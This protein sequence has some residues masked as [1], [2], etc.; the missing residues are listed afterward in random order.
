VAYPGF[1]SRE[2]APYNRE[3]F[4]QGLRDLGQVD[5]K[6]FDI[7]YRYADGVSDRLEGLAK[8]LVQLKPDVIY[9]ISAPSVRAITETIPIVSPTLVGD[10]VR[11]RLAASHA[12]PGGNVTGILNY[13]DGLVGKQLEISR[14]DIGA[15]PNM[16][17]PCLG[18]ANVVRA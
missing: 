1:A 15:Y 16:S 2:S 4:L 11:M 13:V 18:T 17:W 6:T 5:G 12:R 8:E 7:E 14:A 3:A 10:P 9:T